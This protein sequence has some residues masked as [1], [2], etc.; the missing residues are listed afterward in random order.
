MISIREGKYL[1]TYWVEEDGQKTLI[2]RILITEP[3]KEE[4][5]A[6]YEAV[7]LETASPETHEV[8]N[9]RAAF[10]CGQQFHQEA[11]HKKNIQD[12]EHIKKEYTSISGTSNTTND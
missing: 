5:A 11:A 1:C 10:E 12:V 2:T 6:S 8:R 9:D 7:A 3:E 4:P